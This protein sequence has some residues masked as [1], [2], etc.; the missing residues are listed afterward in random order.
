MC[1]DVVE[2]F[3]QP[4]CKIGHCSHVAEVDKVARLL[5]QS[6]KI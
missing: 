3:A 4:E 5:G 6:Y 1:V 2:L